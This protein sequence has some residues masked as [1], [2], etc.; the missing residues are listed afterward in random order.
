MVFFFA[1]A[2]VAVQSPPHTRESS[3][4]CRQ[5]GIRVCVAFGGVRESACWRD[6]AGARES[7]REKEK[8]CARDKLVIF[9]ARHGC[10]HVQLELF[11]IRLTWLLRKPFGS[12]DRWL[13]SLSSKF[14][15]DVFWVECFLDLMWWPTNLV[16]T[17]LVSGKTFLPLA[18]CLP[19]FPTKL[20]PD[21]TFSRDKTF[22]QQNFFPTKLFC[23]LPITCHS[24]R[25]NFFPTKLF[26]D[27]TFLPLADCLLLF[28]TKLFPDKT[29]SRDKTFSQQKFFP[30]K[31][32]CHLPIAWHF[33]RQTR[34]KLLFFVSGKTFFYRLLATF[35]GKLG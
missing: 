15:W 35:P 14:G 19:L 20:F 16:G 28:P 25:Q 27:K 11:D 9:G 1:A 23:H 26:P 18:D 8:A 10:R 24:S 31:L 21:K 22:S 4:L 29:F 2:T 5:N 17:F 32:F 33:F 30:T 3:F 12:V 13:A 6:R 34:L 7:R